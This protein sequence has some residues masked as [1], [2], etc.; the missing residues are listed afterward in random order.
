MHAVSTPPFIA[1]PDGVEVVAPPEAPLPTLLAAA[2]PASGHVAGRGR[3]DLL[4]VPGFTGSKEDFIALVGPLAAR[5]WRTAA[6]DL[7]GQSGAAPL[8][9]RGA[10]TTRALAEAVAREL[11]WF[12]PDRPVHVVGHSMGGLVT[13]ELVLSRRRRLAS[14]TAM[15]SGPSASPPS[16]HPAL[17]ELQQALAGHPIDAVWAHKEAHDRATGWSPPSQEVAD[18]CRRRF[19]T[20]DPAA[21]ADFA[22]ILLT[23]PDLTEQVAAAARAGALTVGVVAGETDDAWP[24]PLQQDMARRL[25]ALWLLL[26]GI[27]HNPGVEDPEAT[28]SAIDRIAG[29]VPT[30]PAEQV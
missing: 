28:A 25:G 3:G 19:V 26:P 30:A 16:T 11:D 27:G 8:G 22:D 21:L 4:L 15:S 1:I 23:A 10:H 18:F 5:G 13:R 7:P 24:A 2:A 20:N 29:S 9:G 17:L 12:A 6:I 14:W